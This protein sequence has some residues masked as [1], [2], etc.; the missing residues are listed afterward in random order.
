LTAWLSG[1]SPAL[2]TNRKP[3]CPHAARSCVASHDA[4]AW[5]GAPRGQRAARTTPLE[6]G[7]RPWRQQ[8]DALDGSVR[9]IRPLRHTGEPYSGINT[10]M[11][12]VSSIE[13]GYFSPHWMTFKQ[14]LE[15]KAAV[16]K[17][18]TGTPVV[19]ADRIKR[20]ERNDAGEDVERQIP[21]L[22][23]YTVFNA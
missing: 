7:V 1:S 22:K 4:T 3:S 10:I 21:F 15:Y 16:R 13:R 19:Y 6:N 2:R 11:L 14:A 20:L 23:S 9:V 8:W 18:E 12:W 17:G 5:Q